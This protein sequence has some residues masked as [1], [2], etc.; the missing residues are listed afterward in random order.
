MIRDSFASRKPTPPPNL[1]QNDVK[2][3]KRKQIQSSRSKELNISLPNLS[4]ISTYYYY[5][6]EEEALHYKSDGYYEDL[7][8][9]PC[10]PM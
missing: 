1:E 4:S 9:M 5:E 8:L 6:M 7:K 3:A 2:S 10:N